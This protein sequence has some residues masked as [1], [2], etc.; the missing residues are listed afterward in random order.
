MRKVSPGFPA[1]VWIAGLGPL[2]GTFAQAVATALDVTERPAEPLA[3]ALCG[4]LREGRCMLVLDHC[5]A[6]PSEAA[7]LAGHLLASCPEL[8][9]LTTA[10]HPLG[11][12]GEQVV[13]T[14]HD[15][16]PVPLATAI[17]S[18][19]EDTQ[20]LGVTGPACLQDVLA[21]AYERL[22]GDEQRFLRG[23][24]L[25]CQG[26]DVGMA[27]ALAAVPVDEAAARLDRLAARELL[28]RR[29]GEWRLPRP[30]R[31]FAI[32]RLTDSGE[33]PEVTARRREW[34]ATTAAGLRA[35]VEDGKPWRARFD[36][37]ADDLR[38]AVR[39]ATDAGEQ[40]HRLARALAEL[41]Y[42]RQFLV[43]ARTTFER[44]AAL[45]PDDR[46]AAV[47]LR[48]AADVAMTE[49]RGE[50]AFALLL[51]AARRS[52]LGGDPAGQAIAL[53]YAV[54]VGNRFPATFTDLV[55][56]ERLC[57]L[58]AEAE[59]AAP[60]DDPLAGAYL[61][62]ARAW[63][64]TGLKTTPD[65]AL[66][67][68]A[69]EAAR[70]TGEAVLVS[71]AL[72]AVSSADGSAGRFADAYRACDERLRLFDRLPR[73]DPRI[74]VEI[75]DTLHVVPLVA[76]AAGSLPGAI[77][78]AERSWED[79]LRGEYMRA[80]KLVIPLTLTGRF[81]EA[82]EYARIMWDAWVRVGR[83]TARWMAPAVH[84]A[85]LV[86][87]L[88]A[89]R[90]EHDGWLDRA[91]AMSDPGVHSG[92]Y[93]SFAAFAAPR[94]ALWR[95]A[96]AEAVA[97]AVNPTALPAWDQAPHQF[98]DAYAWAVAAEAAVVAGLPDAPAWLAA[99]APAGRE[100]AW[101]AACLA[102]AHGRLRRDTAALRE[103]VERWERIGARHERACTLLLLP[104][105]RTEAEAELGVLRCALPP[106]SL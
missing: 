20:S 63:N 37:I 76:L 49:H 50:P 60:A 75:V 84:A 71:A 17:L 97:A 18:A 67:E 98:Y 105:G 53:A 82:L 81:D 30:V 64:A 78:A 73:H 92:L 38:A 31:E 22:P 66:T 102:R 34:A 70:A 89:Q 1:G 14:H 40:P 28:V 44:A 4:P 8:V 5:D 58:M 88:R 6:S 77:R 35:R 45:A 12:P 9:I 86:H 54:C 32:A 11:L 99:A 23:I 61:A 104:G 51:E 33:L 96:C 27:A 72:D 24:S 100:N 19:G 15:G 94:E 25:Y 56:H 65:P 26:F 41:L 57:E 43:E 52:R 62:A 13:P 10:E 103:A 106:A 90:A 59:G 79:E 80:S 21:W 36:R 85:G 68:V 87:G 101:A 74:G 47:D 69:L 39:A 29:D 16:P 93:E 7:S 95:G 46:T 55:P 2:S 48:T 3:E 91:R 42:A 83:P